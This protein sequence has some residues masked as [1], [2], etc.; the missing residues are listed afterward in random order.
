MNESSDANGQGAEEFPTPAS[1]EPGTGS[2]DATLS[3]NDYEFAEPTLGDAEISED[4]AESVDLEAAAAE[5]A[6]VEHEVELATQGV[7]SGLVEDIPAATAPS[8]PDW[9]SAN[10]VL[11]TDFSQPPVANNPWTP[12]QDQAQAHDKAQNQPQ[13]PAQ[14]QPAAAEPVQPVQ[15]TE[16]VELVQTTAVPEVPG[17]P[18]PETAPQEFDQSQPAQTT[19]PAPIPGHSVDD[20]HGWHRPE[21]Q[22]QQSAT[23]WQPKAGAW[24]SPAQIARGEADAAA[25]AAAAVGQPAATGAIPAIPS[26]PPAPQSPAP[27]GAAPEAAGP[28]GQPAQAAPQPHQS[29]EQPGIASQFGSTGPAVPH[30]P[31]AGAQSPYGQA[32][33]GQAQPP[34]GQQPPYG[35]PTPFGQSATPGGQPPYGAS[36]MP[37]VPGGPQGPG[38]SGGSGGGN[39]KKKLFIILGIA[40]L[41][42]LLLGLM[43]TLLINFITSSLNNAG[44]APAT[45]TQSQT[46]PE[47]EPSSD[48][49]AP[50]ADVVVPAASPLDWIQDDCLRDFTG[51]SAPAD[52]VLCNSPHSAQL[53]G[54]FY[55]GDDETFPGGDAL[56]AKAAEVCKGVQL[57]SE[58]E[59]MKDLKQLTAYPSE[60]TWN[61]SGDRRVDC[62]IQD[63][64]GNNLKSSLI[65]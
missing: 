61:D 13:P 63:T 44:P 46:S 56:K 19:A 5:A 58:A 40:V 30:G 32:P 18:A 16:P 52:V 57:T 20:G 54:T 2:G 10:T 64:S 17:P 51:V 27:Q 25:A 21:T 47:E 42:V 34:Y 36:G 62:L 29:A 39:S 24:Q 50:G 38:F 59:S 48:S 60:S 35:A 55:Y 43:V 8:D 3:G 37:A 22:W 7:S 49:K 23:P 65:M 14:A 26:V 33:Y 45:A 15:T 28:Y 41:G 6:A 12:P 4:V 9:D 53:V 1:G 31:A 11:R